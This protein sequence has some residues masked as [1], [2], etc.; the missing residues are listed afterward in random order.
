[1]YLLSW[2]TDYEMLRYVK[3]GSKTIRIKFLSLCLPSA[4]FTLLVMQYYSS[5]FAVSTDA[6]PS[7]SNYCTLESV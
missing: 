2:L 7:V 3:C 6:F 5:F 1:M 4:I